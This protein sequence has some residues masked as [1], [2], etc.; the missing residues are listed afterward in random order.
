MRM[1][2]AIAS[3]VAAM[4]LATELS[5]KPVTP[6][7]VVKTT[8]GAVQGT[9]LKSGVQ[10][11]LGIP[12]AAPPVR[13]LRWREP[14]PAARWAGV[15]HAD[16]FGPQ[17][18]QPQRGIL[19]NQYSGAEV[20]SE[21]CLYLNVWSRPGLKKAPVIV[22]IYGGGFF[23]GSSSMPLYGGEGVA[24]RGAVFVNLNYRVGVL[25]FLSLPELTAES[26][27]K[28]SGNYAFLDQI[29][30]LKWVRDNI[31]AFGGDPNNVTIAGQSA[32]S[33]SVLTLQASPLAKGLF[34]KAVGMSGAQ[35]GAPGQA[36]LRPL[37]SAEADGRKFEDL[38]KVKSLEDL[39]ALPADRL[40]VPRNPGAPAV[41][42][43]MDG[44][45]LPDQAGTIFAAGRQ[46]DVPLM[47]GF[48]H[49]ESFG[50]LGAVKDLADYRARVQA[51][52]GARAAEFL[53]L[54]PARTD[55]QARDQAREADR[56]ATMVVSMKDW[57]RSQSVTGRAPVYSYMFARPHSYAPGVHFTDLDPAT[58]GSYHTSEVPFWLG[59]LDSFNKFRHTRDWTV[60]DW[61]FS[62]AMTD[63]LI[64]FAR[65]GK[66]DTA[67]MHW[68]RYDDSQPMLLALGQTPQLAPWPDQRKLDFFRSSSPVQLS[69]A[70]RD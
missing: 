28:A 33:M 46:N 50:G 64:A 67:Q 9:V 21:D 13:E 31:A 69:G 70:V 2:G 36:V 38:M 43:N 58:A 57:A 42:P 61:D 6:A 41:G 16:H 15:Y 44:Y 52:Y 30:A 23:I 39:R 12:Y 51:R 53:A 34:Q 25:G 55:E 48:A 29:A 60:A 24:K 7:P 32:G 8:G 3:V 49:D 56:D 63:S 65:T 5:A 40:V 18:T 22:Y 10:A 66:P 62:H 17:C 27:H 26:P 19:T 35:I 59:S 14:Q 4:S 11:F 37:A 54:Y 20:T 45:V 47:L 68:P 1:L